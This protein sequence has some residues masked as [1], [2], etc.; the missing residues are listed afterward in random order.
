MISLGERATPDD[1]PL[2]PG[3]TLVLRLSEGQQQGLRIYRSR[4]TIQD[5]AFENFTIDFQEARFEDGTGF[6][7]GLGLV[8]RSNHIK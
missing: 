3:E 7:A 2:Q 6:S 8:P 4:A 1:P 5:S